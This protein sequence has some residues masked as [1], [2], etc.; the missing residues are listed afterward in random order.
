[1]SGTA[2]GR[3]IRGFAP[4]NIVLENS[5][6]G[7]VWDHA[8]N[9]LQA[10]IGIINSIVVG[11]CFTTKTDRRTVV[12]VV[13]DVVVDLGASHVIADIDSAGAAERRMLVVDAVLPDDDVLHRRT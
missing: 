10:V 12:D 1:M 2:P 6:A 8:R 7:A 4:T 11:L 5:A 9:H 13:D 3:Q